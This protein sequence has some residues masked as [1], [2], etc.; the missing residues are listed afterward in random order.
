MKWL[1]TI[2]VLLLVLSAVAPGFIYSVLPA[3]ENIQLPKDDQCIKCHLEEEILPEGINMSDAHL[4][5]GL[6]CAGCHGGDPASEDMEESMSKKAGFI[7]IPAPQQIPGLCGK[8]H[9]SIEIMRQFQPRI[10]TDQ[11]KQF[12][13][14]I[15]G[16]K[17]KAG[18]TKAANCV[19]CHS[20]H[21]I[22]PAK[23]PQSTVHALRVPA[24][25]NTC[26]GDSVYMSEYN[27]PTDQNVDY[28]HSVHGKALLENLDTGSPACNDC[29]G[30]HGAIP[31]GMA[32]I[33]HVC[34]TCHVNNMQYFAQSIMAREFE[35]A[36]IHACEEC[37]GNH[38]IQKPTDQM[39]GT[40]ES[41]VCIKCHQDGDVGYEVAENLFVEINN[42][43][44]LYDSAET[45]LQEVQRIGMDDVEIL[46]LMQKARQDIIQART[47]VHTFDLNVVQEI[48]TESAK[49]T[50]EAV[51]LATKEIED[52]GFRRRGF[53]VAT[54]FI[55]L[56]TVALFFKIRSLEK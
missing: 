41:S 4:Q 12:F 43:V 25:C 49:K 38:L 3:Q 31:P 10:Q 45:A 33:S 42:A 6:S 56:L 1:K 22:L 20:S 51:I 8:C 11:V 27:I 47:L 54:L 37:H 48:T 34:G 44:S 7:G 39:L 30:N 50:S 17:L 28:A 35:E 23:H 24:T 16:K 21:S 40:S 14:S 46:F 13:T 55:T 52:Y 18:D 36:D 19:S 9:S 15:H 32:S 53:G 26:H 5:K 29:H 2:V